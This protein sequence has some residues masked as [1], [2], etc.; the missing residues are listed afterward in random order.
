MKKLFFLLGVAALAVV[1]FL[2]Y[3]SNPQ[4]KKFEE[5]THAAVE[6]TQQTFT[7]AVKAG[8]QK[9]SEIKTDVSTKAKAGMAQANKIATNT[10]SQVREATTNV[11]QQV[12][13][14]VGDTN[15]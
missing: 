12:K 14:T 15:R 11:I 7:N 8:E 9:A 6:K 1:V 13:K 5:K 3:R 4:V 2:F 10:V